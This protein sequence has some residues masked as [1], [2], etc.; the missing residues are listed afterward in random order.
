MRKKIRCFLLVVL[1]LISVAFP[2]DLA[3]AR[4]VGLPWLVSSAYDLIAAV[5][6]LRAANGLAPYSISPILMQTAQ[7]QAD[8]MAVTGNVTH[9]GPGGVT[10][11]QRLLA[12]GYPLAGDLSQGGFRAENITAGG[13]AQDAVDSWTGD[14]L[15]LNTM[16]SPNLTEIGAGVAVNGGTVYYVIDCARPTTSGQPQAF[17]PGTGS[18][19]ASG[20]SIVSEYINPVVTATPN[21]EGVIIHEVKSGQALWSIAIAYGV[22]I[23]DIRRLN[24]L[25][26]NNIFP[27]E[28]L[29]VLKGPSPTPK[30]PTETATI[31]SSPTALQTSTESA[32][33]PPTSVA[34]VTLPTS[35]SPVASASNDSFMQIAI[36]IMALAL[37]GAGLF[38][39]LGSKKQD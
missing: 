30:L 33:K 36:G 29:I 34:T 39:W 22:K 37:L 28:K 23:D 35:Q 6:A 20:T 38:A 7:A 12:A 18:T 19:A 26:N 27:G 21:Q 10:L 2:S 25:P 3:H 24:N 11:T 14:A 32:T 8:F 17:T 9:S 5:N 16:L 13:S 15:H 4:T 31:E 1:F